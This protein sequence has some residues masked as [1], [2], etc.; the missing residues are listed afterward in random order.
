MCL[1]LINE[2]ILGLDII[3]K[4]ILCL[5]CIL[6][7]VVIPAA[8]EPRTF[9]HCSVLQFLFIDWSQIPLG[10]NFISASCSNTWLLPPIFRI[11]FL[12]L[13]DILSTLSLILAVSLLVEHHAVAIVI[14]A[15]GRLS[16]YAPR[17]DGSVYYFVDVTL[18]LL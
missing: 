4:P 14:L 1:F 11:N 13:P 12:V 8:L 15:R 10:V 3:L 7:C 6:L 17:V 16:Y 9:K 18:L 2:H 5:Q